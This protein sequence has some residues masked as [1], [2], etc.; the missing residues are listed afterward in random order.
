MPLSGKEHKIRRRVGQIDPAVAEETRILRFGK[1]NDQVKTNLKKAYEAQS[2][3]Y[4]LRTRPQRKFTV[5]SVVW[6]KNRQQ[7]NKASKY[8]AKLAP[9][10]I[11]GVVS[12]VKG[13]D[14]YE[15]SS[16]QG[17]RIGIYHV[18]DLKA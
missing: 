16:P 3:Y 7:S 5:G 10:F 1:I 15:I 4:N 8:M 2:K 12:E 9:R 6:L 11:K 18:C 13:Q 17:K 14:T